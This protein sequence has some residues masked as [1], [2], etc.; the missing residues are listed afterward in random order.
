MTDK[1]YYVKFII[2]HITLRTFNLGGFIWQ[3]KVFLSSSVLKGVIF[4]FLF[5]LILP[6]LMPNL[7]FMK[8]EL[9]EE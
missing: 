6:F 1:I 4:S 5:R 8:F 9:Y 7:S 2:C 3:T